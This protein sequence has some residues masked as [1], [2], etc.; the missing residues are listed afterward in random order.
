MTIITLPCNHIT[1]SPLQY[2]LFHFRP[3]LPSN[4]IA[5]GDPLSV[6]KVLKIFG[7][8]D[9]PTTVLPTMPT[10]SPSTISKIVQKALNKTNS[11]TK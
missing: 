8:L 7:T 2:N 10:L 11:N 1:L 3:S 6:P 9:T 5:L 4:I